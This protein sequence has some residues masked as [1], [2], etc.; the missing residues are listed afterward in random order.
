[1]GKTFKYL[2]I[3][4][5]VGASLFIS[6]P[7]YSFMGYWYDYNTGW[8]EQ[9]IMRRTFENH[10]R[11][12]NNSSSNDDYEE[13]APP[14]KA[15]ITFKSNGDTRGL[16]YYVNRYPENQR[17]EA[18]TYFKSIQDSFPEV[19]KSVGI[20]TNDLSTG[21]AALVAGAYMA[22]NNVS[23]N[24]DYMKPLQKQ[25]KEAFESV[26]DF[27]KMGD[28]DKKYLYDQMVILGMTLAVTQ[29]QNQ[30]NPN[31]KTTAELRKAGKEVLEGMI[32]VDASQIKITSSGLSF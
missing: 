15:K 14:K 7:A 6:K 23:L 18:R 4:I 16:D 32:G 29:S 20:P 9:D 22:Y 30:Q 25:F 24:D 12:F 2:F 10:N 5:I 8:I 27:D 31:A 28:S 17:K 13:P 11:V 19:A 21:M 1:M 3:T 26:S